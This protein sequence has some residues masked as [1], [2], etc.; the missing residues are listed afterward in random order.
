MEPVIDCLV[1]NT[2]FQA[3]CFVVRKDAESSDAVVID[4]GGDPAPLLEHLESIGV[5]VAGILVT[6]ADSDHI[7]GVAQLAEST[8]AEVWI[9]AEEAGALREGRSRNGPPVRAY[10]PE[11]ELSD[12][13]KLTLA[14][15]VV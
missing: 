5:A 1:I 2:L 14:G 9:P 8:G 4:P 15:L 11:H 7:E 13:D 6:H 10:R 12:G 3:N